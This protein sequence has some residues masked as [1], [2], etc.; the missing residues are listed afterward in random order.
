MMFGNVAPAPLS[1]TCAPAG[2]ASARVA[3]RAM[4]WDRFMIVVPRRL[5]RELGLEQGLR[6]RGF[7]PRRGRSLVGHVVPVAE[8]PEV[9]ADLVGDPADETGLLVGGVPRLRV[10]NVDAREQG[11]LARRELV[12]AERAVDVAVHPG[13]TRDGAL[14]RQGDLLRLVGDHAE[15]AL[16]LGAADEVA[17]VGKAGHPK[18]SDPRG[19]VGI[20]GS[21]GHAGLPPLTLVALSLTIESVVRERDLHVDFVGPPLAVDA[22][23]ESGGGGITVTLQGHGALHAV[24]PQRLFPVEPRRVDLA[25]LE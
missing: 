5:E 1:F 10:E 11:R 8:H 15:P 24:V 13:I 3:T 4:S 17:V 22:G 2:T 16:P 7:L 19:V 14:A 12:Y 25:D 18:S 20:H 9:R 6:A 23:A 21:N